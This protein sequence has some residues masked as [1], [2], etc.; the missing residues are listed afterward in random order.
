MAIERM[1]EVS[2]SV[3]FIRALPARLVVNAPYPLAVVHIFAVVYYVTMGHAEYIAL[4]AV[5]ALVTF[6]ELKEIREKKGKND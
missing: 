5:E 6:H 3:R 1:K 2:P 4:H